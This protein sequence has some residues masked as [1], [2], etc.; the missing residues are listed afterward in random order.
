MQDYIEFKNVRF[1]YG[2]VCAVADINFAVREKA[3]TAFVGPNGGG[4]TT[5]IKLLAGLLKPDDGSI[6]RAGQTIG[7][8]SQS[9]GFDLNF[10]VAVGELVLMGT[11]HRKISPFLR[12]GKHERDIASEAIISAGLSGFE[13]RGISQLSGGQ[14]RRAVIARAL[15]SNADVI[16]LDE[17][18]A[19][20]DIDAAGE[21]FSLLSKLKSDKTIV[22]ASHRIDALLDIADSAVYVNR[23]AKIFSSPGELKKR[24]KGGLGI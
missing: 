8:V 11:L 16:A 17:P 20:L 6:T 9:L 18:D 10:P 21:L 4:K 1:C 3:L 19:G 12:Y 5:L 2:E 24:L 15:A 14:L 7:Y 13:N 22:A 23:Q